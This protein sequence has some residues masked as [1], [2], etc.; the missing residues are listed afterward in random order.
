ML[1]AIG[2]GSLRACITSLGGHQFKLPE[3]KADL[4]RYF[5]VY[6]LVYYVGILLS[7]VVPPEVRVSVHCFGRQSCY[8]AV[9]GMIAVV[10]LISWSKIYFC[11]KRFYSFIKE[12]LYFRF[13]FNWTVFLQ[14]R[15][16]K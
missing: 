15:N 5:S 12:F 4:D 6:Y 7:K 13:L 10:F 11:Y 1:I 16:P 2:N 9:F 14:E 8:T 3:Q